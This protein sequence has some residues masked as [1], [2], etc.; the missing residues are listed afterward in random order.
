MSGEFQLRAECRGHDDDVRGEHM[1]KE[2]RGGATGG[3]HGTCA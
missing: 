3:R 2:G 1:G